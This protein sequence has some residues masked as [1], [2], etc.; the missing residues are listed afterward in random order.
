MV[1]GAATVVVVV[2]VAV[3]PAGYVY[4]HGHL[5]SS[6]LFPCAVLLHHFH[7]TFIPLQSYR[8]RYTKV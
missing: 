6:F 8:T 5:L 4:F 7:R 1:V 3:G 2:V